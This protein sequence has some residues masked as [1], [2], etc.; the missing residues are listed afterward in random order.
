M[1][2]LTVS[3]SIGLVGCKRERTIEVEDDLSDDDLD[4]IALDVMYELVEWNWKREPP[5]DGVAGRGADP[6][7]PIDGAT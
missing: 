1:Q 2:R 3:V 5:K 6:D 7:R 4:A